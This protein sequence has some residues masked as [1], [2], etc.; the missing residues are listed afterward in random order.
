M[1][2]R[3]KRAKLRDCRMHDLRRT[4]GSWHAAGGA[5]LPIS[6]QVIRASGHEYYA[7]LRQAV[8]R[9]G[10]GVRSKGNGCHDH[11]GGR[12]RDHHLWRGRLTYKFGTIEIGVPEWIL[13]V[14]PLSSVAG[15]HCI[16]PIWDPSMDP[17]GAHSTA[18]SHHATFTKSAV[19]PVWAPGDKIGK[20]ILHFLSTLSSLRP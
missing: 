6:R 4:L 1:G 13:V 8:G 14:I 9:C 10:A 11:R 16:P 2:T 20:G 15:R 19:A 5:S 18:Q 17:H 12:H 3:V 7:D